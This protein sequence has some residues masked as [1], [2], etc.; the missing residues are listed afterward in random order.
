MSG[1]YAVE[2][3]NTAQRSASRRKFK[4]P[5]CLAVSGLTSTTVSNIVV[6]IQRIVQCNLR[7]LSASFVAFSGLSISR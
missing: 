2:E 6:Q 1:A 7:L 3:N 5:G 4:N